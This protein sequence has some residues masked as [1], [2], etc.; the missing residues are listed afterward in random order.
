M[1]YP[2]WIQD[3]NRIKNYEHKYPSAR[4]IFEYPQS[5]W[6]GDNPKK[7]KKHME[8]SIQRLI[9]RANPYLPIFVIYNIPN[10]DI[11]QWSKGGANN[12]ENYLDFI[13]R[14]SRG[15]GE[16]ESIIVYEPD[17]LP[18]STL[19]TEE[20]QTWRLELMKEALEILTNNCSGLIYVD[21]GHSNWLDP[22]VVCE[23]LD[24]VSNP[25][26]KGFS[27]NSC[28]YRTTKEAIRW[29]RKVLKGR[30]N[31]NFV[32]DTSRNGNGPL[33]DDWC[34][35]SGRALGETPTCETSHNRCDAYLW[36]KIPGESDG[37]CNGG[38]KA[39][40]FWGEQA[41]ELVKNYLNNLDN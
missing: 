23:L 22:K 25:K 29:S 34:N 1:E 6:F 13:E 40:M 41:E 16:T 21:V 4:K 9:R 8:K 33:D 11:G 24:K 20:E 27:V 26:V 18:H 10:R 7:P 2:F 5:F 28:N 19:L 30:E 37:K 14:F 12:R 39:G 17:A 3:F 36:V 15:I 31:D 38:P 35:P 32:I